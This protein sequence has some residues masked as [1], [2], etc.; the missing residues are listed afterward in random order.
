MIALFALPF[1]LAFM[2]V[3]AFV[4]SALT[5]GTSFIFWW[6]FMIIIVIIGGIYNY[7]KKS[8]GKK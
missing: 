2:A 3:P 6:V 8:V 4:L 1:I 7:K 5:G